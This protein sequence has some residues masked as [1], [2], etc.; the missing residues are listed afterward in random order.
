MLKDKISEQRIQTLHP[1]LRNEVMLIHQEIDAALTGKAIC[2]IA[3][4]IRTFSEQDALY[5]QGRTK[6]FDDKGK[7]LGVVTWAKGGES[8]HNYGLAD[9]I[10]LLL[11]NDSNGSFESASWDSVKDFDKDNVSDWDEVVKIYK[12]YGWTWGG[13]WKGGK[14]DKPHFQK[15]FSLTIRQCIDKYNKKDFIPGTTYINI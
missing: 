2:R 13:D 15:S 3:Y 1:K 14:V 12:K 10:V 9:D 6:L 5:A 4:A 8:F 11:D 7:R